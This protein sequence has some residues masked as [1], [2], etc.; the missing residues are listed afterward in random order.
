MA[1]SAQAI[2]TGMISNRSRADAKLV[3]RRAIRPLFPCLLFIVAPPLHAPRVFLTLHAADDR[4]RCP[5]G[6]PRPAPPP[7]QAPRQVPACRDPFSVT[8]WFPASGSSLLN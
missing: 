1:S 7:G 6:T 5:V 4:D 8:P 2:N 3:N